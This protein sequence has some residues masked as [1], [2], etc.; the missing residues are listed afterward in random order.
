MKILLAG[1]LSWFLCSDPWITW[2]HHGW[3]HINPWCVFQRVLATHDG[4]SWG[5]GIY[6]FHLWYALSIQRHG[7]RSKQ[8]LSIS[9]SIGQYDT[10]ITE[11]MQFCCSHWSYFGAFSSRMLLKHGSTKPKPKTQTHFQFCWRTKSQILWNT[12]F[13]SFLNHSVLFLVLN[14]GFFDNSSKCPQ[15][16]MVNQWKILTQL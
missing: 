4:F 1:D 15:N 9:D 8:N 6:C 11:T 7:A 10:H 13:A 5:S 2:F 12:S 3:L 16:R 14:Q